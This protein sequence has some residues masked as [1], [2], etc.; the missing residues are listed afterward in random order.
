MTELIA[1][2]RRQ[3][4]WTILIL[5][6]V[7]RIFFLDGSIDFFD[8][9]QYQWRSA[10]PSVLDAMS[11][12]HAP[13]HP[14]YVFFTWIAD[15]LG[16]GS[17]VALAIPSAFASVGSLVLTFLIGRRLFSERVA[18]LATALVAV[19]PFFW[20]SSLA[21][22]VDP[23]MIAFYLLSVWLY[24]EWLTRTEQ[25]G[26]SAHI[27]WLIGSGFAFG[28]SMFA[29]TLVAFWALAFPALIVAQR[30]AR[31]WLATVWASIPW[32]IGPLLCIAAYV[33]LLLRAGH[34]PDA[35]SALRYLLLGNAGDRGP[36]QL[37]SGAKN[38]RIVGGSLLALAAVLGSVR[39]LVRSPRPG[40]GL[41]LW[42]WPG[43]VISALYIYSNLAGRA[44][45]IGLVPAALLAAY[46]VFPNK[47]GMVTRWQW[48]GVALLLGSTFLAGAPLAWSYGTRTPMMEALN[49]ARKALPRGGLYVSSNEAKTLHDYPQFDVVFEMP[50]DTIT[51]DIDATLGQGGPV[52]AGTDALTYP[53]YAV[54][55]NH[56]RIHT[57]RGTDRY[58]EHG[59]LSAYLFNR[60]QVDLVDQVDR[61]PLGIVQLTK[62]S[63]RDLASRYTGSLEVLEPGQQAV[64]GRVVDVARN[65]PVS[66]LQ[67][68]AYG[69][70][71]LHPNRF[72]RFDWPTQLGTWFERLRKART[73]D[74]LYWSYTDASGVVVFPLP[75][76]SAVREY[77][78]VPHALASGGTFTKLPLFIDPA[79]AVEEADGD[80]I[81]GTAAE[82]AQVLANESSVLGA[83]TNLG[84]GQY[85]ARITLVN[86]T[87][88][89]SDTIK[90]GELSGEV[91]TILPDG[92]RE[93]P[94]GQKGNVTFGPWKNLAPG[95]Y[96]AT[97]R[98]RRTTEGE[99]RVLRLDVGYNFGSTVFE[100][101]VGAGDLPVGQLREISVPFT[102]TPDMKLLEFRTLALGGPGFVVDSITVRSQ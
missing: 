6:L 32:A 86:Y 69:G 4:I 53:G 87:L 59:S 94:A 47:R 65:E 5:G 29:H 85:R 99:D 52:Y 51:A 78:F 17:P 12:G 98:I 57:L 97:W 24:L 71:A 79:V 44:S 75:A 100:Q 7:S 18:W 16:N 84:A 63:N 46:L 25:G 42:L 68:N 10:L 45:L 34:N 101:V 27:G 74:P 102:I 8:S 28:M 20:V 77:A 26:Y 90:A 2:A 38:L 31:Q 64:L 49:D 40:A 22:L 95:T 37:V 62:P 61:Y 56:W 48:T 96:V 41:A 88:R 80:V 66:H 81:E 15:K 60:Y 89:E 35:F 92:S 1:V 30:P 82:I 55:G 43:L 76:D 36:F 72:D 9:P 19:A 67:V 70:P 58:R 73:A 39:L 21:I 54:D 3:P 93:A 33:G 50:K 23:V 13:Y 91:S 14:G 11:A 83:V